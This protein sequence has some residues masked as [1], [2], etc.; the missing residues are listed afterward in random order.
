MALV[1]SF[2]LQ[3][4]SRFN[5]TYSERFSSRREGSSSCLCSL[6]DTT[7]VHLRQEGKDLRLLESSD[8]DRGVD[9]EEIV[10]ALTYT[11]LVTVATYCAP[12]SSPNEEAH[13]P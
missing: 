12:T 7:I 11:F 4:F 10:G 1:N 8:I 9:E 3:R 2:E 5:L 13:G 6:R